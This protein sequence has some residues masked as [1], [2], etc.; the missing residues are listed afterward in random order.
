M[1]SNNLFFA[2][3]IALLLLGCTVA[4]AQDEVTK[5]QLIEVQSE[6]K[7]IKDRLDDYEDRLQQNPQTAR[8]KIDFGDDPVLGDSD[9]RIAIVEF[10]DYQCPFCKHFQD[11]VF[12]GLKKEYIDTGKVAFVYK[13]LPLPMHANAKTAAVAANCANDQNDY[14]QYQEALFADQKAYSHDHYIEL[15]KQHHLDIDKFNKC[16]DD[17]KL[18]DEID[19]DLAYG[20]SLGIDGTPSFFIGRID[21]S[22]RIVNARLFVGA[23]PLSVFRQ[24]LD[25]LLNK[26]N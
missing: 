18:V 8:Y 22:N 26:V 17:Q 25:T 13:D 3:I 15:A 16:L 23:Q 10:S 2:A 6:L 7:A 12:P 5:A 14:W 24:A 19:D 1:R 9:A 21:Q 20:D 11:Q 4:S